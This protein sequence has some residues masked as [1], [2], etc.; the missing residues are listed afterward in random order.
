MQTIAKIPENLKD[1]LQVGKIFM[2]SK[3]YCPYC[4]RAKDLLNKLKLQFECL[5]CDD[6]PLSDKQ[7]NQLKEM[8][9]ITTYPN[10]F[11]GLKSI[12]G[13]DDLHKLKNN[14]QLHKI[15]KDNGV[16]I[17]ENSSL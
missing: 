8:S 3:T 7:R 14:G 2:F 10:I 4:D 6:Y 16:K 1:L 11:I 9:G 17:P 5:E 13:C 12:G 15:L